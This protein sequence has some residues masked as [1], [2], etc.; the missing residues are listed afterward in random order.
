LIAETGRPR[1]VEV[2]LFDLYRGEQV[3]AGKKSL[4]YRLTFQ[5]DEG[6]LT[7]K[8]AE[9]I[10]TKIVKRLAKEVGAVLRG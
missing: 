1:L 5:S 9:K 6:T 2:R 8:D 4:A 7:D 3:G 10:R